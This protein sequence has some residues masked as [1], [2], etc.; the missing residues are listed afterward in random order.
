MFHNRQTTYAMSRRT[1]GLTLVALALLVMWL[2][3]GCSRE[4]R[5]TA[6]P[7]Q[8][9]EHANEPQQLVQGEQPDLASPDVTAS[10]DQPL[11]SAGL[12]ERVFDAD[13]IARV[14]LMETQATAE[15]L[16]VNDDGVEVYRGVLEFAFEVLEYLKSA[17]GEELVVGADV[18]IKPEVIR[19]I[20]DRQ[21]RGEV[22]HWNTV[23]WEKPYTT[24]ELAITA[25]KH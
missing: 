23:D 24:M 18:E 16:G 1:R 19:D 8:P 9:R 11:G 17:G 21:S 7:D 13:V 14:R 20:M 6:Q 4:T 22:I 15:R 3:A 10:Y 5:Q 12:N 2:F 25:A